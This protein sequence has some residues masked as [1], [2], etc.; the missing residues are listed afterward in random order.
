VRGS[1]RILILLLP[2]LCAGTA[3]GSSGEALYYRVEGGDIVFTNVPEGAGV[4]AV[5]GLGR[6]VA[7]G[8]ADL[9]VTPFDAHIELIARESGLSP[10]LIKA[11]ALVESGFDPLAV[12]PKGA[13]GLMQLMPGTAR[14]YGVRD[15]FDPG[16]NLRAG[17]RHLRDL[18][19]RY[20]GDLT[21]ALAAYNAGPGAVQRYGGVPAY[22]ETR[23]YVRKVQRTLGSREPRTGEAPAPPPAPVRLERGADGTV[24][25]VN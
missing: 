10:N 12:S 3:A 11:V 8:S 4:R 2:A 5:P 7:A 16:E 17:A 25:L 6:P 9:P 21:L 20:G 19:D 1:W 13:Q 15:A 18:L 22:P 23:N 24:A 14:A